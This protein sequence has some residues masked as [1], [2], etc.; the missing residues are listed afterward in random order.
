MKRTIIKIDHEKCTGCGECIPACPEGALQ[1]IDGKARLISDRFCDGLGA[2]IGDCPFGAISTEVRDAVPYDET[3][4]IQKIIPQ[5]IG[6]IKAHL[7][8]LWNH[9]EV[10]LYKQAYAALVQEHI[11]IPA[12][13]TKEGKLPDRLI[14]KPGEFIIEGCNSAACSMD[15]EHVDADPADTVKIADT[16]MIADTTEIAGIANT[17]ETKVQTKEEI[18]KTHAISHEKQKTSHSDTNL[19]N[20]PIK[21]KLTRV[22]SQTFHNADLL[23]AADCVPGA[24]R[25]FNSE[26]LPGKVLLMGCPKFDDQEYYIEKLGQIFAQ[27]AIRSIHVAQMEIPCCHAMGSIISKALAKAEKTNAIPVKTKIY[28]VQTK[29]KV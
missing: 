10:E 5:G 12:E 8:H 1:L 17:E 27:N 7:S 14:V 18:L 29:P 13:F 20:W 21:I 23:I 3:E 25:N 26:I 15:D 28:P 9:G 6:T 19:V 22:K 4:V 24:V 2:C 11:A 16:V